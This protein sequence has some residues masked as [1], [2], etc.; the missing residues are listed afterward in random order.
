MVQCQ[1]YALAV[2]GIR[3]CRQR[4]AL[5][6]IAVRGGLLPPAVR[7][8]MAT[9]GRGVKRRQL[10]Q[11]ETLRELIHMSGSSVSAVMKLLHKLSDL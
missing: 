7:G 2:S 4:C 10:Y 11:Y 6:L 5:K 9:P 1:R 8:T 3:S